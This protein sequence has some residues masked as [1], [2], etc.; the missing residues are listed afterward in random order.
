MKVIVSRA[1]ERTDEYETNLSISPV[2]IE[3]LLNLGEEIPANES[4]WYKEGEKPDAFILSID[5]ETKEVEVMIYDYYV[6]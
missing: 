2:L 5:P 3:Q 1:S 6:E 4:S